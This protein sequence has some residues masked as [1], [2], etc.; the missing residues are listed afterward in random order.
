[1]SETE[2]QLD[3]STAEVN[4]G[5]LVVALDHQPSKPWAER[6]DA[7]AR[8]LNHGSWS[9]V[10]VKKGEVRVSRVLPGSEDRLRHFLESVVL[11]ANAGSQP[12]PEPRKRQADSPDRQMTERFRTFAGEP[13]EEPGS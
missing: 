10:R 4:D 7:T 2:A 11:E 12:A 6:F 1:M 3:W 5:K 13:T 9:K 8:L